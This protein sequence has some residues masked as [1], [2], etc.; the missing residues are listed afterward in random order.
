MLDYGLIFGAFGLPEWGVFGAGIATACAEWLYFL[1]LL[2]FHA[3]AATK[4]ETTSSGGLSAR[5]VGISLAA[6][7]LLLLGVVFLLPRTVDETGTPA[8]EPA[9]VAEPAADEPADDGD[10]DTADEDTP[11][12]GTSAS[13]LAKTS[14]THSA[15]CSRRRAP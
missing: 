7:L 3:A 11:V 9:I 6:L 4:P 1:A 10:A 8:D 15:A 5:T 13:S 2:V 14:R 12:H